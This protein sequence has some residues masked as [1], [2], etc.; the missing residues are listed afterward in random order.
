[1][2]RPL[3]PAVL[4]AVLTAGCHLDAVLHPSAQA[5][6]GSTAIVVI[7]SGNSQ[8]DTIGGT[9]AV[10]Y[11][12]AVTDGGGQPV[13]GAP[14][15]WAVTGGGGRV[16]PPSAVTDSGGLARTTHTLGPDVGRQT[17]TATVAGASGSPATFVATATGGTGAGPAVSVKAASGNGQTDTV[18]AT[19]PAPFVVRVTDAAGRPVAGH[20]VTWAVT[21][22]RGAVD[23]AVTLTDANG[24][25]RTVLTLGTATGVDT[26]S[27]IAAGLS[28]APVTFSA[29]ATSGTPIA[30]TFTQQP[31]ATTMGA[32]IRPPVQVAAVDQ[33][34]NE[35]AGYS[36]SVTVEIAPGTG[37]GFASLSGTRTR[38]AVG[39]IATFDDLSIDLAGTGYRLRATAGALAVI[40]QSFDVTVL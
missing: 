18:A 32:T 11:V 21:A 7:V 17:V 9:L 27:A 14:V 2:L 33:F 16:T 38:A 13:P 36:G 23:S 15:T 4:A 1:M 19:L 5:R 40:S 3:G 10:P 35:A 8:T 25:A 26:V 12:V 6:G 39:G 29:T 37:T 30:L 24:L 20:T 28:A 22:G 34:G 31:T